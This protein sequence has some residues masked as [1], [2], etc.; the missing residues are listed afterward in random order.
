MK[1]HGRI[2]ISCLIVLSP[3]AAPVRAQATTRIVPQAPSRTTLRFAYESSTERTSA[4]AQVDA[5][6]LHLLALVDSMMNPAAAKR[7]VTSKLYAT[8]FSY[9]TPCTLI[10]SDAIAMLT[11]I[12]YLECQEVLAKTPLIP[13]FVVEKDFVSSGYYSALIIS[14][15][16]SKIKSLDS[17]EIKRLILGSPNS[18][19]SYV[20]PLSMLWESGRIPASTVWGAR[21]AFAEVQ[22]VADGRSVKDA[23]EADPTAIGA[24]SEF[25]GDADIKNRHFNILLRYDRLPQTMLA[26]SSN[27]GAD[28]ARIAAALERFF[29]RTDTT[30]KRADAAILRHS[31]VDATGLI[32]LS[33]HPEY[34]G[35][36]EQLRRMRDR[37]TGKS[38][39]GAV[40]NGISVVIIVG[41]LAV[42]LMIAVL[43]GYGIGRVRRESHGHP[44][45]VFGYMATVVAGLVWFELLLYPIEPQWFSLAACVILSAL[46]GTMLRRTHRRFLGSVP[47]SGKPPVLEATLGLIIASI[48]A[49][50]LLGGDSLF[51]GNFVLPAAQETIQRV[52]LVVAATSFGAAWLL[53]DAYRVL[54]RRML[55]RF[56]DDSAPAKAPDKKPV[57]LRSSV[58]SVARAGEN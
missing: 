48:F 58:P 7:S 12:K 18:T 26:V 8:P 15:G 52:S 9:E 25:K 54:N 4:D 31:A 35:A 50:I 44:S 20:A 19:S 37:V 39:G 41:G 45:H 2:A 38:V 16:G 11:P 21:Q 36:Y 17:P 24:V 27:L 23:I 43:V 5:A 22:V 46:M 55:A 28:T 40:Y 53:E 49:V 6:V 30:F 34:L 3:L 29:E 42:S 57:S 33:D 47:D 14:N 32:R 56:E 10:A 13:L 1:V 51:R